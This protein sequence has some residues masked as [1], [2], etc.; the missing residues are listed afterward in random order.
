MNEISKTYN[1]ED[2][3]VV[4]DLSTNSPLLGL[5]MGEQTGSRILQELWSYVTADRSSCIIKGHSVV[6]VGVCL[7]TPSTGWF[8]TGESSRLSAA[9]VRVSG[10]FVRLRRG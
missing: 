7:Y 10:I 4:T 3:P 2:S 9:G 6:T 8:N 1:S 5:T